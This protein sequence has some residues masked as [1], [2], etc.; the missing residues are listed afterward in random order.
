VRTGVI[1]ILALE[2]NLSSPKHSTESLGMIKR[3]RSTNKTMQQLIELSLEIRIPA[4]FLVFDYQ[5]I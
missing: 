4:S 1:E 3:R 5:F 2:P